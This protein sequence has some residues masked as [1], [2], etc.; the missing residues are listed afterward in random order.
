MSEPVAPDA[1]GQAPSEMSCPWCAFAGDPRALHT[2]LGERHSDQVRTTERGGSVLYEIR[3]PLCG[4]CYERPVRKAARD[5]EFLAGFGREIAMV[6][7]DMLVHHLAAEHVK[8]DVPTE[9]ARSGE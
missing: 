4:A 6:A 3:C 9:Q 5:P 7:L 2:H 1:S 8:P